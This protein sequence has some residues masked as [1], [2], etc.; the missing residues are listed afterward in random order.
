MLQKCIRK[1]EIKFVNYENY[2]NASKIENEIRILKDD[3]Y[4]VDKMEEKYFILND[5]LSNSPLHFRK[6]LIKQILKVLVRT[7]DGIK[8]KKSGMV[9]KEK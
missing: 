2:S 6:N 4:N 5:L 9:L 3:N 7:G 1:T 8:E